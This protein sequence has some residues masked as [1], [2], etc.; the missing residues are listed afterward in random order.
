MASLLKNCT[1]SCA[2]SVIQRLGHDPEFVPLLWSLGAPNV[3]LHRLL[4]SGSQ[5]SRGSRGSRGS[6]SQGMLEAVDYPLDQ[7]PVFFLLARQQVRTSYVLHQLFDG[8][9]RYFMNYWMGFWLITMTTHNITKKTCTIG[10]HDLSLS[11]FA[12]RLQI[13]CC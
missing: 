5:G 9:L 4:L 3:S 7:T 2:P 12:R 1:K 6:G 11:Y 13:H 10:T 8:I